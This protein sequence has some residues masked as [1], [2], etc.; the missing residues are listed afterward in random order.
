MLN[1]VYCIYDANAKM[2][3]TDEKFLI[4]ICVPVITPVV[5]NV[6]VP[7]VEPVIKI[8]TLFLVGIGSVYGKIDES[9]VT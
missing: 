8:Y 3:V 6:N 7:A 2:I 9:N 5:G 1:P 4:F